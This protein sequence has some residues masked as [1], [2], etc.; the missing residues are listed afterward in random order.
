M[1]ARN[2]LQRLGDPA[3]YCLPLS[4][5]AAMRN[6]ELPQRFYDMFRE[7]HEDGGL[8]FN[9]C[10]STLLKDFFKVDP[11][12]DTDTAPVAIYNAYGASPQLYCPDAP[13]D[14]SDE[15]QNWSNTSVTAKQLRIRDLIKNAGEAN[16]HIL[17]D[18]YGG[19]GGHIA[20]LELIDRGA[21]SMYTAKYVIRDDV[22]IVGDRMYDSNALSGI[23]HTLH[24]ER[25][26]YV[27]LPEFSEPWYPEGQSSPSLLILPP[28]PK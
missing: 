13:Y 8:G 28:E 27:P 6:A 20:G 26:D 23:D 19:E 3:G 22:E 18:S 24:G 14:Y 16:C 9:D 12:P 17:F 4:L 2:Q 10:I 5:D 11:Q 15:L 7:G 21:G 25:D 1:S